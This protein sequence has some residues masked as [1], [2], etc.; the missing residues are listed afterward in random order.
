MNTVAVSIITVNLNNKPGLK[1]T[2]ESILRQ[3]YKNYEYIVIDGGSEDGSAELIEEFSSALTYWISEKDTG[4]YHAMNK[5]IQQARGTYCLFLNSGDWL[6]NETVLDQVFSVKP[7]ADMLI[8]RCRISERGKPIFI[9]ES[10]VELTLKAFIGN[11]LPHQATF[12]KTALFDQFGH[13][14]EKYRINADFAFWIRAIIL[15]NCSTAT[16]DVLVSDYNLEGTSSNIEQN[17]DIHKEISLILSEHFPKRVLQDYQDWFSEKQG[18]SIV[19]FDWIKSQKY[20]FGAVKIAYKLSKRFAK[21][22]RFVTVGKK[23][24]DFLA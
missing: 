11:T 22:L 4:I 14:E 17:P 10:T 3:S 5:G 18:Q 9:T 2:I 8:G 16:L 6:V 12:I 23:D 24:I 21:L 15:G 7:T 19:Y 20:T 1:T 13:Y